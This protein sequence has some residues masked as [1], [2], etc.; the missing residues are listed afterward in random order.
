M[1]SGYGGLELAVAAALS[2]LGTETA[3]HCEIDPAAV[4][5][6]GKRFPGTPNHGDLTKVDWSAVEPVDVLAMGIPCEPVSENGKRLVEVDPRWLWPAAYAGL[7]ALRPQTVVFE[8]V[9]NLPRVRKGEVWASI[10]N[11]MRSAGYAVRWCVT[12]ACTVG[13]PHCRHRVFALATFVGHA[14]RAPV[15]VATPECGKPGPL[16]PTPTAR[17]GM[18]GPGH[19]SAGWLTDHLGRDD[20]VRLAGKG[21][22]PAQGAAALSILLT[23]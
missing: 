22:C 1:C 4:E 3:W 16:L 6:L 10:L 13:A 18:G 5:T 17:D 7:L 14:R 8:N 23:P 19:S 11:D 15:R 12:G 20:A 21:V 9:R 2:P